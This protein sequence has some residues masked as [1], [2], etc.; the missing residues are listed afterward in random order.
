MRAR[1]ARI[2]A[3]HPGGAGRGQIQ[4]GSHIRSLQDD[5]GITWAVLI[6]QHDDRQG[7]SPPDHR[8]AERQDRL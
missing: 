2:G 8:I 3:S 4:L 6:G 5:C 1:P 7:G